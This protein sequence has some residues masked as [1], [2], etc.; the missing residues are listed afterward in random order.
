MQT[1]KNHRPGATN[2][3]V[4]R[5]DPFYPLKSASS[6]QNFV[7]VA[8]L[9]EPGTTDPRPSAFN[10]NCTARSVTFQSCTSVLA[11]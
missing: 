4:R 6:G 9:Q 3:S 7:S 1:T 11:P 10:T 8:R 5:S 2:N